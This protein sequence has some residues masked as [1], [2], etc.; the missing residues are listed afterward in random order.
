MPRKIL[1]EKSSGKSSKIST[2]K[3]LQH[4]SADWPGQILAARF[5]Y[6]YF[7]LLGGGEGGVRGDR[8]GGVRFLIENFRN[9]G[10]GGPRE[11]GARGREGVCQEVQIF[12]RGPKARQELHLFVLPLLG[13][14]THLLHIRESIDVINITSVTPENSWGHDCVILEGTVLVAL[15]RA[16]R[17]RFGY[18]FESCDANGPRNVKN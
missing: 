13:K 12:F 10:A 3:I 9:V 18:G 8:E 16:I 11:G 4:I 7:F 2:P 1:Q 5:G 14:I 15:Y 17:L 6:F